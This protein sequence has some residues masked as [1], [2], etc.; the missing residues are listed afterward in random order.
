MSGIGS[1]SDIAARDAAFHLHPFTSLASMREGGPLVIE[2][3]HGVHVYDSRGREFIDAAAGLWCVN[4]GHGRREIAEAVA[5]QMDRLSYIQTFN[6]L[7]HEAG[8]LL[9]ERIIAVAPKGMQRVFFGNSGSD[10]NDS[11]VK[12]VWLFNNLLKRPHKKKIIARLGGYHGV[13]VMSGSLTGLPSV[14]QLF[15]LPLATVR[16]VSAPDVYRY[17]ERDA[18]SYARELDQLL[19]AEGPETVAAFIAEP[20]MG[21][22]GVLVPPDGYFQAIQQVL[23]KHD[24]LLIFDEVIC[25][26]GRLGAW[27]GAGHFDVLPDLI[28]TAKGLTSSYLPMSAVILGEKLWSVINAPSAEIGVFNHGFTTSGHPLCAAVA[29]ANLDIIERENL[30]A[31][32]SRLGP[33]LLDAIRRTCG[34]HPLVGDVRGRGL[35]VGLELV[36]SKADKTHFGPQAAV[37]SRVSRAALEEGLLVR[38]LGANDVVALSPPFIIDEATIAQIATR[39]A[40]ALDKVERELLL[41]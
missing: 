20:V 32:A 19:V 4:I 2:R 39:L 1:N 6:G 17:P 34:G 11:A 12:I 22:G 38:A 5:R 16:H 7:T 3:A 8:A 27:F 18:E 21:T 24:V 10:A 36:A 29:I 30:V 35:M 41:S 23:T 13:T 33:V 26:F 28:T 31:R 15:D 14:H 9:A 40:T 37:A 25:G